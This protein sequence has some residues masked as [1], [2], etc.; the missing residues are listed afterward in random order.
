MIKDQFIFVVGIVGKSESKKSD[1]I[2]GERIAWI[3]KYFRY[4]KTILLVSSLQ[5][6]VCKE[7]FIRNN[8][9]TD[10]ETLISKWG[11]PFSSAEQMH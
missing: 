6:T 11:Y 10:P 4:S 3:D 1:L 7:G 2:F 9:L 8:A 5:G